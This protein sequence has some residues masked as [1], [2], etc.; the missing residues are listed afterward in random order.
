MMIKLKSIVLVI[1]LALLANLSP[2]FSQKN[3]DLITTKWAK[4]PVVADGLLND[5]PDSLTLYN[6]ETKLHY[7]LANDET[8]IYLALKSTSKEDL[9]KIFA[10]GISFSAN[11][12]NKKKDPATVIFPVLDR[13]PGKNRNVREQPTMDEMQ[14]RVLSRIKDIK[15][16]GFKKIID[17]GISLQN[18][19]G[20]R[21]AV[22]FDKNNNLVQEI[23]IPLSLLNLSL[24][25]NDLVTY[26][27]KINGV[28]T[29]SGSMPQRQIN[30]RQSMGGMYEGQYPQRNTQFNK[31]LAATDFYIKSRL[32]AKE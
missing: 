26:H 27:I 9:T 17:G 14:K 6:K 21:A 30:Q 16:T 3:A 25:E 13:T 15:V 12:E 8:N 24:S 2:A 28:Q 5:W 4:K 20:I 31:L 23:I 19:Y 1:A 7:N 22:A 10:G 32:A 29:P 18:S 11:L